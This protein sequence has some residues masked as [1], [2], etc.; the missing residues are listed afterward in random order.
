VRAGFWPA[1]G[2]SGAFGAAEGGATATPGCCCAGGGAAL[3]PGGGC[4]GCDCTR[5]G[6]GTPWPGGS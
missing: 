5:P 1:A 3:L 6:G 4:N 2:A